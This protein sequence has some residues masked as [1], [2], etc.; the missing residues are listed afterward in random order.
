MNKQQQVAMEDS[1]N[2]THLC[3][4]NSVGAFILLCSFVQKLYCCKIDLVIIYLC[5][6]YDMIWCDMIWYD[7]IDIDIDMID[8]WYDWYDLHWKTGGQAARLI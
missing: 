1:V 6:W 3:C 8:I 7:S 4:A 5:F 2:N